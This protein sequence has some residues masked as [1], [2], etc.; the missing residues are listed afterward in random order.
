[1][2]DPQAYTVGWICAMTTKS[3]AAQAFFDGEHA[4]PRQVAQYNNNSYVLCRISSHNVVVT[5]LPDGESGMTLAATVAKNMLYSFLNVRIRLMVGIRGGV[6]GLKHDIQLGDVAFS[7][8]RDG[9]GGPLV[10]LQAALANLKATYK[11]I[12]HQLVKAVDTKLEKIKKQKKYIQTSPA[13]DR[14]YKSHIVHPSTPSDVCDVMCG[15]D[16]AYLVSRDK[17]DKEDNN[18]AIHYGLIASGNQLIKD[19]RKRDELAAERGVLCFEIE[20]AG[21]INH[22]PCLVI[23]GICDYSDSHKNK[24]WQGFAAMMAAAYAKVLLLRI[25]PNNV[26]EEE[27][28][29]DVLN[30]MA[31]E[32]KIAVETNSYE[33]PLLFNKAII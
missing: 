18:P 8:P 22:F 25:P 5:A 30:T 2:S 29:L 24:E 13:S 7:S 23:R 14:L 10:L 1:M 31:D 20:A 15:D 11:I 33:Y 4:A 27:P 32:T 19:A 9:K 21:L 16:A 17:R 3:V 12:G 28:I 26:E 6:P